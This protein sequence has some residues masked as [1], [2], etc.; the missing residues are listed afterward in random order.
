MAL[1]ARWFCESCRRKGEAPVADVLGAAAVAAT[2]QAVA[3]SHLAKSP[4]CGGAIKAR[5]ELEN[6]TPAKCACNSHC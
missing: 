6:R 1:I 3:D 4:W 2:S 5:V